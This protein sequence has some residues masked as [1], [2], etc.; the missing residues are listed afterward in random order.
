MRILYCNKYNFTFSG[1]ES[2]LFE[3]MDLVRTHGHEAAL[4]S[5]ADPRGKPTPYDR[6]FLP[7]ADFKNGHHGSIAQAKLAA[8]ALY[9]GLFGKK[10]VVTVQ[11]LDGRREKWGAIASFVL[12]QS[13]RAAVAFPNATVVV[14]QTLHRYFQDRYGVQTA[15]IPNGT[16]I[17]KRRVVSRILKRGLQ[18]DNYILFLGRFSPEKNCHLLIEAYKNINTPVK[19][20]LAGGS[21]YSDEY[22]CELRSHAS[23]KILLLDWVVGRG[24][25]RT[26]HQCHAVRAAF[27]SRRSF[28]CF[29]R[30]HGC[31]RLRIGQRHPRK[32]RTG[33]GRRFHLPTGRRR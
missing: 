11:G 17:R 28:P 16:T 4:F 6:H 3:V 29:A 26:D 31:R 9:S 32:P 18:P 33:G 5:M 15:Y 10:T 25:R 24:T 14:S 7:L 23:E 30:R 13:E 22:V 1:T 20:V 21:S 19:L 12:R 8:R 27:R 2:Y